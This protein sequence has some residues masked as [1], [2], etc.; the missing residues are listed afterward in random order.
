MTLTQTEADFISEYALKRLSSKT[1]SKRGLTF[2]FKYFSRGREG[3]GGEK[4]GEDLRLD[5]K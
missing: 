5:F 3:G 4:E 1:D 2:D